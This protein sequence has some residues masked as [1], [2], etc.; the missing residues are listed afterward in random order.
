MNISSIPLI[1]CDLG[2]GIASEEKIYPYIDSASIACGGHYGDES[3]M[4]ASMLLVKE[5]GVK[6]G[7]HP[8]YPDRE[9]FGRKSLSMEWEYLE[10]SLIEQLE[11]FKKMAHSLNLEIH[12]IK[13]H[14]A[15]YNDSAKSE[16]LAKNLT[17][18]YGKTFPGVPIFVPANSQMETMAKLKSLPVYTEVFGDRTYNEDYSLV[19]RSEQNSLLTDLKSVSEHLD[20]IISDQVIISKSGAKLPVKADTLCFHGDNPGLM[21]FLPQIRKRF[22]E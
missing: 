18:L 11:L 7:A 5:N 19:S 10:G 21:N 9:N 22:W 1:N 4:I 15:L 13:S 20:P 14:G 8:S 2:E 16:R 17:S 12:H 6:I 3:S